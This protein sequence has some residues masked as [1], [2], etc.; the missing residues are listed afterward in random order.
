MI[1]MKISV[2]SLLY[3]HLYKKKKTFQI[4]FFINHE[5]HNFIKFIIY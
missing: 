3:T 5:I 4:Y 2:L 1:K